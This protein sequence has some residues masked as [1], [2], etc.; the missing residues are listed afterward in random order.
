MIDIAKSMELVKETAK[1]E[2]IFNSFFGCTISAYYID[3]GIKRPLYKFVHRDDLNLIDGKLSMSKAVLYEIEK[4]L[5]KENGEDEFV[6]V[7]CTMCHKE[8]FSIRNRD[9]DEIE[10]DTVIKCPH[11][12]F[13]F[14]I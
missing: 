2:P 11:C 5:R 14:G 12:G 3:D 10:N 9:D 1:I 8:L 4:E 7:K 6:L 13:I